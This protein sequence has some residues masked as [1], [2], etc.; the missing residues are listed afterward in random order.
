MGK[1]AV[2]VLTTLNQLR[3]KEGEVSVLVLCHTRELADQI[4]KEYS[5]FSKYLPGVKAAVIIGGVP[6][7]Q[8]VKKLEEEKPQIIIGT[9][10]RVMDLI[11]RGSLVVDKI[12]HFVMD[13][14]DKMLE[15][16]GA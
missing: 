4:A 1:T 9:P 11:E 8:Q 6:V 2:F 10:G 16:L 14:C 7:T 5:R 12:K 3:P 13:E 15:E